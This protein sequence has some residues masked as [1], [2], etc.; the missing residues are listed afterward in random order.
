MAT[1][2]AALNHAIVIVI[3]IVI[4]IANPR[5]EEKRRSRLTRRRLRRSLLRKIE[6]ARDRA[7]AG[8]FA[9]NSGFRQS[10]DDGTAAA[11][12]TSG[13]RVLFQIYPPFTSLAY[14]LPVAPSIV[15]RPPQVKQASGDIA[16]DGAY[17]RL[18]SERTM[19]FAGHCPWTDEGTAP[20]C[21]PAQ[22]RDLAGTPM[23]RRL[24]IPPSISR[25]MRLS[26]PR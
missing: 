22:L 1:V 5:T 6:R 25:S 19:A 17:R 12:A 13:C 24:S 16:D 10:P 20:G 11:T 9:A 14:R 2:P 8:L 4:V 3:V 7:P 15:A 21:D 23:A 18:L 26:R